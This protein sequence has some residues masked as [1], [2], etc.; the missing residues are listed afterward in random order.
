MTPTSGTCTTSL[1]NSKRKCSP[2]FYGASIKHS[3]WLWRHHCVRLAI[4]DVPRSSKY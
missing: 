3:C 1:C 4:T 2:R